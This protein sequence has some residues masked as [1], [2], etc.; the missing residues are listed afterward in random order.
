MAHIMRDS[1]WLLDVNKARIAEFP[2]ARQKELIRADA[3]FDEYNAKHDAADQ[4]PA[5]LTHAIDEEERILRW[6]EDAI[7]NATS[8]KARLARSPTVHY[9]DE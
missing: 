9:D 2:T 5:A 6:M 8:F 1:E 3:S 7:S 4:S